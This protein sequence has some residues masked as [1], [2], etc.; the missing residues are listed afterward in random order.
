MI[1]FT[2]TSL[3]LIDAAE[4]QEFGELLADGEEGGGVEGRDVGGEAVG[5]DGA[6]GAD[7]G[8]AWFGECRFL[9]VRAMWPVRE[10]CGVLVAG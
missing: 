9:L 5:V 3:L 1:W 2:I 10:R 6:G 4:V 7:L 8:D